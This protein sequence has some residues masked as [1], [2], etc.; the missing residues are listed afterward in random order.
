ML[1]EQA[2]RL[3]ASAGNPPLRRRL[4]LQPGL[5]GW[6]GLK[7][8]LRQLAASR[9]AKVRAS[10]RQH[11]QQ[12]T[13]VERLARGA[14]LLAP[15]DGS[16]AAYAAWRASVTALH[17]AAVGRGCAGQEPGPVDLLWELHGE[18]GLKWFYRLGRPRPDAKVGLGAVAMQ[19]EGSG[20][21]QPPPVVSVH[22]YLLLHLPS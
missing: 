2:C 8:H 3:Y 7:D 22:T 16:A 6:E 21:G 12:A 11:R 15:A 4:L 9:T 13:E 10:E 1:T 18:Q 14:L 5:S 19:R 20:G 17:A